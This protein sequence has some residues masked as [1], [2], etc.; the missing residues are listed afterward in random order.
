MNNGKDIKDIEKKMVEDFLKSFSIPP[1]SIHPDD[2]GT[3]EKRSIFPWKDVE[4]CMGDV[5]Q[6]VPNRLSCPVCGKPSEELRWIAF[7]TSHESWVNLSGR[8]GA[9]SIC[10]DCHCQ[11][12][13][14]CML[15]N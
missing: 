3:K 1:E 14:L 12:E 9:M 13:F 4:E 5:I 11:V 2:K 7:S 8:M 10:T 15:M 6:G